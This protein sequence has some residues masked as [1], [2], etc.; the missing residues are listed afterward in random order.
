M[1]GKRWQLVQSTIPR[2]VL[3]RGLVFACLI[4]VT[5]AWWA[6]QLPPA[7]EAQVPPS[8]LPPSPEN[9]G[10][11]LEGEGPPG[12]QLGDSH[13]W[14]SQVEFQEAVEREV[15]KKDAELAVRDGEILQ[16][17]QEAKWAKQ[18]SQM[19]G[20]TT[21]SQ[22]AELDL[23]RNILNEMQLEREE[24]AANL[25][26]TTREMHILRTQ[27]TQ[28][29]AEKARA[30]HSVTSPAPLPPP[31]PSSPH[32]EGRGEAGGGGGGG[33]GM[34]DIG[35]ELFT[36]NGFEE[37]KDGQTIWVYG[38]VEEGDGQVLMLY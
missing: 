16:L 27:L 36:V 19:G 4:S 31:S 26:S 12:Y 3:C 6:G 23:L 2:A 8:S 15:A 14:F 38:A 33:E 29:E 17:R 9:E 32:H 21:G 20:G 28:L 1:L 24:M 35:K 13:R 30:T 5:S 22:R 10:S 37:A 11:P 7:K 34:S 18:L 25:A